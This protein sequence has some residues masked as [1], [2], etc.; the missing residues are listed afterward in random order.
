MIREASREGQ[1]IVNDYFLTR[2]S[3]S[4]VCVIRFV[5]LSLVT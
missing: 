5:R 4:E 1:N 2:A 3:G